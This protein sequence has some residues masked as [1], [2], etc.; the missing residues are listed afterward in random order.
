MRRQAGAS[1]VSTSKYE[2][3]QLVSRRHLQDAAGNEIDSIRIDN[4]NANTISDF[5]KVIVAPALFAHGL[6]ARFCPLGT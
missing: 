6:L 1:E 4:W 3:F 5:F 2:P